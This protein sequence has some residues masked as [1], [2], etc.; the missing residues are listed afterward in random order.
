M[1]EQRTALYAQNPQGRVFVVI[2]WHES[3]IGFS[4]F[5]VLAPMDH[6]GLVDVAERDT[7][8]RLRYS[9][10]LPFEGQ[11]VPTP[12]AADTAVIPVTAPW[13]RGGRSVIGR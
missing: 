8:S 4:L 1:I 12:S 9:P 2:G 13:E 7:V 5:P 11:G 10:T 6:Q 3:S